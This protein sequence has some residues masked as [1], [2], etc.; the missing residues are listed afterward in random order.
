MKLQD[1]AALEK[2]RK[3][4]SAIKKVHRKVQGVPSSQIASTP[5]GGEKGQKLICTKQ[6]NKCTRST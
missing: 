6:T 4:L 1:R 5:R 3:H 2:A